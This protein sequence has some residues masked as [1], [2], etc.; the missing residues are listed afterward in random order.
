MLNEGDE[1]GE[2]IRIELYESPFLGCLIV[3]GMEVVVV[4]HEIDRGEGG[5]VI[6]F[7]SF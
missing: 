3:M 1:G 7:C 2:L 6:L 5:E 4:A